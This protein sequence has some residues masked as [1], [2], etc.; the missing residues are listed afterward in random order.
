MP[1][2]SPNAAEAF[3]F[4][5]FDATADEM[6]IAAYARATGATGTPFVY[7]IALLAAPG[8][9]EA[10]KALIG[11]DCVAVHESQSFEAAR[12]LAPGAYVLSGTALRQRAP[13]RLTI[14]AEVATPA[15]ETVARL[16]TAL[17]LFPVAEGAR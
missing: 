1:A 4:G 15:G 17:R 5:P 12:P 3:A 6:R 13:R 14:E 16:R 11:A 8:A 10:L 7:P 9:Q 2:P